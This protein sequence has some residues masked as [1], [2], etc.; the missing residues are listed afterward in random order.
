MSFSWKKLIS[1]IIVLLFVWMGQTGIA[2][3]SDTIKWFSYEDGI[4]FG[5]KKD[6]NI[7]LH[8]YTDW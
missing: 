3:S 6:K 8:F 4:A 5:K 7:M 1:G 2:H